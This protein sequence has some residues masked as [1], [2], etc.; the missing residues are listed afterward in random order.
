MKSMAMILGEVGQ[1]C[2]K[3]GAVAERVGGAV[4]VQVVPAR[5]LDDL[6]VVQELGTK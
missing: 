4:N 5:V 6:A 1:L 3:S 2:G